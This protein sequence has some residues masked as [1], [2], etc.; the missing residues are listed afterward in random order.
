MKI[1][2]IGNI[3]F[4]D[5]NISVYFD[6]LQNEFTVS[7]CWQMNNP[8]SAYTGPAFLNNETGKIE[9]PKDAVIPKQ[10]I[11]DRK[12]IPK[13]IIVGKSKLNTFLKLSIYNYLERDFIKRNKSILKEINKNHE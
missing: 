13:F 5:K 3:N 12:I 9:Y 6:P 2:L 10:T 8:E 1:E 7:C 11:E 4:F